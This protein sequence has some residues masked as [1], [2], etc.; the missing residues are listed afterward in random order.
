MK[1]IQLNTMKSAVI[2]LFVVLLG[3]CGEERGASLPMSNGALH[4]IVIVHNLQSFDSSAYGK[5]IRSYFEREMDGLANSEQEYNL[6]VIPSS[7]FGGILERHSKIIVLNT[8]D[9]SA[10]KPS[11][12]AV[13]DKWAKNQLLIKINAANV[14]DFNTLMD[15]QEET[16]DYVIHEFDMKLEKI[17]NK[18]KEN[19]NFTQF[20]QSNFGVGM[21]IPKRFRLAV[22]K[23]DFAWFRY[24]T[25]STSEGI[26]IHREPYTNEASFD[27]GYII[28]KRDSVTKQYIPGPTE[29]SYMSV[30]PIYPQTQETFLIDSAYTVE[31]KGLWHLEQEYMG[32]SFVSYTIHNQKRNEILTIEAFVHAPNKEKR[33]FMLDL[34]GILKT[35]ELN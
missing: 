24:E 1:R 23:E 22:Q 10:N 27:Y 16:I 32:G 4:E 26:M 2:A 29:G 15:A 33:M 13:A 3:S 12:Q 6:V 28:A 7:A 31:T 5:R 8:N 30:N 35:I 19:K 25:Q 9:L 21:T 20:I 11:Y 14:E 17:K 18:S 34:E